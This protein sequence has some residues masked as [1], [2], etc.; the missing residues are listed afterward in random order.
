MEMTAY[1]RLARTYLAKSDYSSGQIAF[2][3][4]YEDPNSFF[5]AFRAWTGQTPEG[6]RA[7]AQ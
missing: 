5:R 4:G 7:Q 6:V 2:L 3:L 1:N